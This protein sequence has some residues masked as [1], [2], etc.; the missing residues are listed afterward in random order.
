M[1]LTD[2]Q[3][4]RYPIDGADISVKN[5]TASTAMTVGAENQGICVK[6][7][8]TNYIASGTSPQ[9]IM[10][11]VL[12]AAVT[13]IPF[14]IVFEDIGVGYTGGCQI[15]GVAVATAQA[16]ITVAAIVGPGG[17]TS[18]DVIAYTATD[19]YLGQCCNQP[20]TAG[21]P[22]FVHLMPGVTA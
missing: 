22:A 20:A 7:D 14:G 10:G 8:A 15:L 13:D 1:A 17:S 18:G 19:P 12:T 5:T 9:P 3:W 2:Y 21:D 16:A 11:V 6:L 4:A